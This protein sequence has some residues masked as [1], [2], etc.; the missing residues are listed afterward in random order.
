M[1]LMG[2][3]RLFVLTIQNRGQ[4]MLIS[5]KK[6]ITHLA[7][8][9]CWGIAASCSKSDD[10]KE[11]PNT[12]GTGQPKSLQMTPIENLNQRS[13]TINSHADV[14]SRSSLMMNYRSYVEIGADAVQINAPVYPRVRKMADGRYIMF[15]QNNQIG[16]DTYYV[17]SSDLQTWTG[18][19]RLFAR[20]PIVDQSGANNERRFSTCN[21][22]VLANGDVIAVASYRANHNYRHLPQD[23]GLILSRS[24]DNGETWSTPVEIYQGTNWEPH[25]LQLPSGEIHCYFTDS[26]THIGEYNTGTALIVSNDNGQTWTP[27]YGNIPYRVIRQR[28]GVQNGI[29]L[30]TDQ[31]PGVI[32]LNNS[33]EL[34][35]ALESYNN[36]ANYYLS[37]AYSG[38]SG[39]WPHLSEN[40]EG[41]ADRQ[42]NI[43]VGAAPSLAQFPS[44]ETVLS[45]NT[46]GHFRL[47]MGDATAR[48]FGEP[49]MP[50]IKTGFWGTL[51]MI[52][53]HQIIGAMHT[54]GAI[55]LARFSLNHQITATPRTVNVDGD[56]A[57]WANTDD[58]L[59]VGQRS[60]AQ[61]TLRCA[62]DNQNIY[63][64]V[65][66]LDKSISRD[67]YVS[68]FLTPA[69]GS[70]QV[71]ASS[72]RIRVSHNGLRS[73]DVFGGGWRVSDMNISVSSSYD[74][75]ISD[76]S[77]V[78]NGYLVEIA[79]PKSELNP[80]GGDLLVNFSLFDT[81]GGE[82]AITNTADRNTANW[83]PISYNEN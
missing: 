12:G 60:Q 21:A 40:E 43:F 8:L 22:L 68:I 10:S 62:S 26:R 39:Q 48:T 71:N 59:F 18:G 44:G 19:A 61:A 56:N 5:I 27:S 6:T 16:A 34:V 11:G 42:N 72:R 55:M 36:A 75:T 2:R 15:Y 17:V 46:G 30:Y 4:Q 63:F 23:N 41:P 3:K 38:E 64:L 53:S 79:V 29:S 9:T 67:D 52:D 37:L 77:D 35:A 50:F 74:G 24:T 58:A 47:R 25:L 66:V 33:N 73:V 31:M 51:E 14:T 76:N 20:H 78:D 69:D 45:Y 83:I 32:K 7:L 13:S 49:Y 70:N 57:E 65:E 80:T 82:D 28:F 54:S 81:Q 1:K